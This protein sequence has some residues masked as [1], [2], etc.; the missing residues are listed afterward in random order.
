[1]VLMKVIWSGKVKKKGV[2]EGVNV[3]LPLIKGDGLIE[4]YLI[5]TMLTKIHFMGLIKW[6]SEKKGGKRECKLT[7]NANHRSWVDRKK[8]DRLGIRYIKD[9]SSAHVRSNPQIVASI[10]HIHN[11]IIH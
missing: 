6:K 3:L 5:V 4:R 7:G 2:K 11:H 1:M 9:N 10:H 8:F